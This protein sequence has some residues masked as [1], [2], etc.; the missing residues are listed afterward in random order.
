VSRVFLDRGIT[1]QEDLGDLHSIYPPGCRDGR[2]GAGRGFGTAPRVSI[3]VANGYVVGDGIHR[4]PFPGR[5]RRWSMEEHED[6]VPF[7]PVWQ[8]KGSSEYRA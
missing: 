7:T 4:V 8:M 5:G 1:V 3:P 6:G 2:R